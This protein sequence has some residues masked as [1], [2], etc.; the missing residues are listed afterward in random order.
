MLYKGKVEDFLLLLL[1]FKSHKYFPSQ[2]ILPFLLW[3]CC[4]FQEV[5]SIF[6][7]PWVSSGLFMVLRNRMWQ[8][9][10]HGSSEI[11]SWEF[12]QF[13]IFFC[14]PTLLGLL[15]DE[16][17]C[18]DEAKWTIRMATRPVSEAILDHPAPVTLL[19]DFSC[20]SK[21]KKDQQ[22]NHTTEFNQNCWCPELL[23]LGKEQAQRVMKN[24]CF[25]GYCPKGRDP[26]QEVNGTRS[27][28]SFQ[29][30]G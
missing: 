26:G 4:S 22:K 7:P 19:D 6:L 24:D 12:L 23:D 21:S 29:H 25:W 13:L 27:K 14:I 3:F 11:G 8:H 2:N 1:L 17:S 15:G 20:I 16:R 10:H 28:I 18:W 30:M 5:G 9:C